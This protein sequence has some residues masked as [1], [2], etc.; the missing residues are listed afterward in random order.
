MGIRALSIA[1]IHRISVE[2]LGLD[3][4]ALDLNSAEA[5][6]C[7]LRRAAG[8]LCPCSARTLVYAVVEPLRGLVDDLDKFRT[9]V[10]DTLEALV[11]YGDLFELSDTTH[12]ERKG[13]GALLYRAPPTFVRRQSGAVI[14]LGILPDEISLLPDEV[15]REIDYSNHIRVLSPNAGT[16]FVNQ[17]EELGYIELP[18]NVWLKSPQVETAA[19]HLGYV[20]RLLDGAPRAGDVPGLQLLD[21]QRPVRH[22]RGRWVEPGDHTGR[23]VGRRAQAYGADVWCYVEVRDGQPIKLLD[24]PRKNSIWRGCDE[25]WRIQAAIDH[26]GGTPQVFNIRLGP[27]STKVIDFFSPVPMWVR[28]RMEVMGEPVMSSASLFSYRIREGELYE[29]I[30]FLKEHAWLTE[31]S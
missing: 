6:A 22:Y 21:P 10:E 19:Q 9:M 12:E 7:C 29:E 30:Q 27:N 14:L 3:P 15:E 2:A 26:E 8:F 24:L 5:V 31:A 1:D 11:A 4:D 28:R 17:L 20:N 13:Q 23:F 18:S 25:A 16:E